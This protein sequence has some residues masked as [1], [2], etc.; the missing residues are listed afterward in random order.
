MGSS[1]VKNFEEFIFVL[2]VFLPEKWK[3]LIVFF[4][5]HWGKSEQDE[6]GGLGW[7]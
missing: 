5:V 2:T 7:Q 1:A 4:P 6:P 3:F